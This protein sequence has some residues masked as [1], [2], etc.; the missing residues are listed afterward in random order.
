MPTAPALPKASIDDAL[1][2]HFG[3]ESLRR[4]Q[5]EAVA[6][7]VAGHNTLVVMPTGA[8]KSLVYQLSACL[9]DGVTVVISPLIAL[10][11]DQV[12]ALGRRGIPAVALNS[13]MP[14]EQQRAGLDA[15]RNGSVR[16]VYVAPERLRNKAFLRA[17]ADARVALLAVDEAHCVSRC[18]MLK[19]LPQSAP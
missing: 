17:L 6:S 19:V 13:S 14:I 3:F 5:R 12:D 4:G 18:S 1:R 15:L 16:L 10:M 2:E 11:K 7:V 8:G 9:L